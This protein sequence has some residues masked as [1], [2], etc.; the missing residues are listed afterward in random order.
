MVEPHFAA[1]AVEDLPRTLRRE[2]EARQRE[3]LGRSI[4]GSAHHETNG[5]NFEVQPETGRTDTDVTIS[6]LKIPFFELMLFF[7]K[8]LFAAL[9]ALFLLGVLLWLAGDILMAY[10]PQLVK[11][12]IIFKIP[13]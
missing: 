12:Q 8:A 11:M 2:K 13:N 10:F 6:L 4:E 3:A 5:T 9:P 7:I 1:T